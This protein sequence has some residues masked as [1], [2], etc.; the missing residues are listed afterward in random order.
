MKDAGKPLIKEHSSKEHTVCEYSAD[1]IKKRNMIEKFNSYA[2]AILNKLGEKKDAPIEPVVNKIEQVEEKAK[3]I[4]E[5]TKEVPV[6]KPVAEQEKQVPQEK[7]T[8]ENIQTLDTKFEQLKEQ[9]VKKA[10]DDAKMLS[11]VYFETFVE[12]FN[13]NVMKKFADFKI[14]LEKI[15]KN[16]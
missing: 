14:E 9:A 8:Q 5:Q 11:E 1:E 10:K 4:V 15:F 2:D 13:K 7:I 6:V 12:S 16:N 3:P